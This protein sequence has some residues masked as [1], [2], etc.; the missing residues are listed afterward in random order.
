MRIEL[1]HL[2]QDLR[3][4]LVVKLKRLGRG[5]QA[6]RFQVFRLPGQDAPD[7]V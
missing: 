4:P 1:V 7:R 2:G 5:E 6:E 3:R